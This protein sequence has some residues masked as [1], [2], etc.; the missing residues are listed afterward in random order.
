MFDCQVNNQLTPAIREK[1]LNRVNELRS[2]L[3]LGNAEALNG[4][5]PQ[6]SNIRKLVGIISVRIFFQRDCCL[7][8][9]QLAWATSTKIGCGF[10]SGCT[11]NVPLIVVCRLK[12]FSGN[13]VTGQIYKPGTP[14]SNCPSGTTCSP[15]VGLC[16]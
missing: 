12:S 5:A 15:S 11:G 9:R 7:Q 3:A 6:G 8:K 10:I 14:C 1:V 13:M 16:E 2:T 4:K